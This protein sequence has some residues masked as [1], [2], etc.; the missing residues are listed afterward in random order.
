MRSMVEG[1]GLLSANRYFPPP[2]R[3]RS[4]EPPRGGGYKDSA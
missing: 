4:P 3:F 2:A 1:A